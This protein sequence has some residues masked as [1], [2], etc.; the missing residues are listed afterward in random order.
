MPKQALALLI[1]A[2]CGTT[3]LLGHLVGKA[4][5]RTDA[6]PQG[7]IARLGIEIVPKNDLP[8]PTLHN[9]KGITPAHPNTEYDIVSIKSAHRVGDDLVFGVTLDSS[10][11]EAAWSTFLGL[12]SGT[13]LLLYVNGRPVGLVET[14]PGRDETLHVPVDDFYTRPIDSEV[15]NMILVAAT[16]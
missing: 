9:V 15:L 16:Q 5:L 3:Y 11:V 10:Q 1:I 2:L 7:A 14:V 4:G 13:V 6:R 12:P 8:R